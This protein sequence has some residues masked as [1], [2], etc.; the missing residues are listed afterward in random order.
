MIELESA[1]CIFQKAFCF[2]KRYRAINSSIGLHTTK[3]TLF[4]D[5]LNGSNT[6]GKF[7][8][9]SNALG[10]FSKITGTLLDDSVCSTNTQIWA[11]LNR[12]QTISRVLPSSFDVPVL[13][14]NQPIDLLQA[15]PLKCK[16]QNLLFKRLPVSKKKNNNKS[17]EQ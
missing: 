15:L 16:A 1:N 6:A 3:I 12:I 14:L 10:C 13:L 2:K 8:D 7:K 5:A 11:N 17:S 9:V 4:Y